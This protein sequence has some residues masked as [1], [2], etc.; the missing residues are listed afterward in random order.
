[1]YVFIFIVFFMVGCKSNNFK[2]SSGTVKN[3]EINN[4]PAVYNNTSGEN[5][6]AINANS[7][8]Q[9]ECL[10]PVYCNKYFEYM[11]ING[12]IVTNYRFDKANFFSDGLAVIKKKRHVRSDWFIF[13]YYF[14]YEMQ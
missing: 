13:Q 9:Y 2:E 12:N 8:R 4:Q 5:D 6:I 7:T 1:M 10:F 14:F 3:A 11:D